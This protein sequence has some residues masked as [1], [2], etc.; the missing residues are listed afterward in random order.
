MR[1]DINMI[2]SFEHY[3]D[4]IKTPKE[5]LTNGW[6]AR[7]NQQ[8]GQKRTRG[9]RKNDT[10]TIEGNT[11]LSRTGASSTTRSNQSALKE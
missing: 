10:S 8:L 5:R 9:S 2:S 7:K 11:K 4:V 1:K 3:K 6:T